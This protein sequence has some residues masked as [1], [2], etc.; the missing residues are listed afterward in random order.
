MERKLDKQLSNP[1]S[2]AHKV[3]NSVLG[4]AGGY[5]IP[6]STASGGEKGHEIYP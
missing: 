5:G 2:F 1:I 3:L 4:G 6:E